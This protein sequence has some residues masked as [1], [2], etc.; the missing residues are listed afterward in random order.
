MPVFEKSD[1]WHTMAPGSMKFSF[2]LALALTI[3]PRTA[4]HA[5]TIDIY[6]D[7]DFSLFPSPP[8]LQTSSALVTGEVSFA[9]LLAHRQSLLAVTPIGDPFPDHLQ[10]FDSFN[11]LSP[12]NLFSAFS[13]GPTG[14]S[15]P[16]EV[17]SLTDNGPADNYLLESPVPDLNEISQRNGACPG[18]CTVFSLFDETYDPGH[19]MY[20]GGP[21]HPSPV[22]VTLFVAGVGLLGLFWRRD[23]GRRGSPPAS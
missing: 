7:T 16:M 4:G 3:F 22:F 8:A 11:S 5:T 2:L 9:S 17:I 21:I 15:P 23:K 19:W 18:S 1:A 20:D 10:S 14:L 6:S 12:A 13:T